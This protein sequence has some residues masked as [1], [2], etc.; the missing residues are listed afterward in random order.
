MIRIDDRIG[1]RD[2]VDYMPPAITHIERLPYG[3]AE[4]TTEGGLLIGF[5][6]KTLN[7][8]LNCIGTGRFSGH[9][10]PGLTCRYNMAYLI[11]EGSFRS[12]E[13]G[14]LV[15]PRRGGLVPVG[16]A[17]R[18][19]MWADLEKWITTIEVETGIKV[20]RAL[21]RREVAAMIYAKWQWW[22]KNSHHAHQ[23]FDESVSGPM[24]MREPSTLRYVASRLPGIGWVKSAAVER[25]FR[26]VREMVNAPVARW[27]EIDGVGKT[28]AARIDAEL[29]GPVKVEE[30]KA[31]GAS[32]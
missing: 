16:L 26:S 32:A 28:L 13:N 19:F 17:G 30:V 24:S 5:E 9:Q 23:V 8:L 22:G 15:T 6:V 21:S 29:E 4:F 27:M 7:D 12:D 2:L 20:R 10:L 31:M 11:V 1:S 14:V 25:A 3:D 18:R